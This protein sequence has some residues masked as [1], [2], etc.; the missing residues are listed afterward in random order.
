MKCAK[1]GAEI[2][3]G[4]LYCSRCGHEV[5]IVPD[6]NV[7]EEEVLTDILDQEN[8]KKIKYS[9]SPA[10]R[11]KR[12][13]REH[14]RMH[15]TAGTVR[16]GHDVHRERQHQTHREH[17]VHSDPPKTKKSRLA[18]IVAISSSGAVLACFV[19]FAVM[20]Y[21]NKHSFTYQFNQALAAESDGNY[22]KAL[23]Y[24]KRAEE[25]EPNN[26][27][28]RFEMADVYVSLN[29]KEKAVTV[30]NDIIAKDGSNKKAYKE[31]IA[32]YDA[33]ADY[34]AI[35]KLYQGADNES[36]QALF[37]DYLV[38]EP[39]F[40]KKSGKYDESLKISLTSEDQANIYYTLDGTSPKKYGKLYSEPIILKE[41]GDY[42]I[43]AV[44]ENEKGFSSDVVTNDYTITY[45][46][47]DRPTLLPAGG[48]YE[49]EG[50]MITIQVPAGCNA[51]YIWNNPEDDSSWGR[52][53]VTSR[54]TMYIEPIPMAP[55]N[56]I[57]EVFTVSPNGKISSP[58]RQNYIYNQ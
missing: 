25:T 49:G 17:P 19:M 7:L 9:E 54:C 29:Q 51:Y 48:T 33:D 38:S 16:A 41:E 35:L 57:L 26:L 11:A 5:Q 6:Y 15:T 23:E 12:E 37:A 18:L 58:V 27:D 39:K 22:T 14:E 10:E 13:H 20:S 32:L 34:D 36:I 1:C 43:Q 3:E 44:C 21:N 46:V 53:E 55:G 42:E 4:C 30:L 24:L 50:Q 56:N 8:R 31:L 40:S 52:S 47:P 2:K 28:V 45:T